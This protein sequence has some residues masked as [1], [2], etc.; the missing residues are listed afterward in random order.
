MKPELTIQLMDTHAGGDVSRIVTGGIASLPGD[1]VRAQREY[2][3]GHADGLRRLLLEESYGIW[4]L[5]TS[6]ASGERPC[7]KLGGRRNTKQKK[8]VSWRGREE[9][10]V[11]VWVPARPQPRPL[12]CP[13]VG[14]T[15]TNPATSVWKL[16]PGL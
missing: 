5:H 14:G 2:L 6:D 12:K 9:S 3:R 15:R 4:L 11:K 7:V 1:T 10:A 8:A 16:L 13:R